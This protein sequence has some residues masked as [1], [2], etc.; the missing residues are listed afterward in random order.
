VMVDTAD[1]LAGSLFDVLQVAEMQRF[2]AMVRCSDAMVGLAGALRMAHLPALIALAPD[3]A[4]FRS[5]VCVEG[6]GS[7]LDGER[8]A[9]LVQAVRGGPRGAVGA[10]VAGTMFGR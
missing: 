3:F 10:A 7:A 2:V 4:G 6:R 9:A 8:L 5:A 1:K